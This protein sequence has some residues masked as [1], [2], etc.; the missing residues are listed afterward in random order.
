GVSMI[1]IAVINLVVITLLSKPALIL[2]HHYQTE[3][4]AGRNPIF[5]ASDLPEIENVECWEKEDVKDYLDARD[6]EREDLGCPTSIGSRGEVAR[7]IQRL[8]LW[9]CQ[10][11]RR[12]S[13]CDR[14]VVAGCH[15][16]Q[17]VQP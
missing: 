2:F 11:H 4:K 1:V 7:S 6:G 14:L 10:P 5:L 9:P 13:Y 3:R 12:R 17:P 8:L 15:P 16:W